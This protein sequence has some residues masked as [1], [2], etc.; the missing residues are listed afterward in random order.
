M[1]SSRPAT[2]NLRIVVDHRET[3]FYERCVQSETLAAHK[4]SVVTRNLHLGDIVLENLPPPPE[5]S[6]NG[7]GGGGGGD[8]DDDNFAQPLCII[9]R[10][11]INDLMASIRDGRY[12]EQ[13]FRL[14]YSSSLPSHNIV[15][16]LEGGGSAHASA[17]KKKRYYSAMTSLLFFKGF[18]V[19]RTSHLQESVDTIVH[20][21][22]KMQRDLRKG[23]EFAFVAAQQKTVPEEEEEEEE[24][25]SV[26]EKKKGGEAATDPEAKIEHASGGAAG[27]DKTSSARY[28]DVV[29]ARKKDNL[30]RGNIGEITL[31]QVPGVSAVIAKAV[32][33][34]FTSFGEFIDALR[35]DASFLA[36]VKIPIGVKKTP[37]AI[38]S[39]VVA[40]IQEF[41]L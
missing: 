40:K 37:R 4:I 1:S 9:E 26:T 21:A 22:E 12:E 30:T 17:E 5:K 10:K 27:V 34:P 41:F 18:S 20:I 32:M 39:S 29:K 8:D 11:T 24:E 3:A 16:L 14:K 19:L 6:A 31:C 25:G 28:V 23:K 35:Q 38:S 7:G 15:Y 36:K 2:H 13:S 33:L